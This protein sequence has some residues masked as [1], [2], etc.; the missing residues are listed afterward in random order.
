VVTILALISYF[1]QKY[2]YSNSSVPGYGFSTGS[3][4]FSDIEFIS[5]IVAILLSIIGFIG[6]KKSRIFS[7]LVLIIWISLITYN[8]SHLPP[9]GF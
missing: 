9:L 5:F 7:T 6:N 4:L 2:F 3:H 1:L 8:L